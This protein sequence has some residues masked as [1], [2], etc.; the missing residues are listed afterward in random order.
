KFVFASEI[1]AILKHPRLKLDLDDYAVSDYL[2]LGYVPAPKSIFRQIRK[3]RPG[4]YLTV[5]ADGK[6][7]EVEYWDLS[8]RE[9][10]ARSD[11]EWAEAILSELK[12]AVDIRLMS[13]VPLGAFLSG[14]L[15]SSG[16][17]A[18]MSQV[19]D[20]PVKSSTIGFQEDQFDESAYAR[21][22]SKHLGT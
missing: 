15:D 2:S 20:Q 18:M 1:K 19:L 6:V 21:R 16:V 11:A 12:T 14:G 22:V 9:T 13:E 10:A 7:R 8:F 3:L 5:S 17:V 4:H